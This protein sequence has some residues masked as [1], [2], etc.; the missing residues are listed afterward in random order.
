[1]KG[2]GR[3]GEE[4]TREKGG[5]FTISA[6]LQDI[7]RCILADFFSSRRQSAKM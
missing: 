2:K 6:L 1:M 3:G 7:F 4:K 5:D